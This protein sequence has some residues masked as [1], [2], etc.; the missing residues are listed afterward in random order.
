MN[1]NTNGG[2][3]L[4]YLRGEMDLFEERKR[5]AAARK[6]LKDISLGY[7][8]CNE[9]KRRVRT[10]WNIVSLL[11]E[12]SRMSLTDMSSKLDVPVSTLHEIMKEVEKF[13]SFTIV[14]KEKEK[15]AFVRNFALTCELSESP[16][17]V[18]E[19]PLQGT[20]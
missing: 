16:T 11:A 10:F 13:F 3:S 6:R 12:N 18:Q 1:G 2:R 4:A 15:K 19:A 7:W 17:E 14:L 5:L 9:N 8:L 20:G